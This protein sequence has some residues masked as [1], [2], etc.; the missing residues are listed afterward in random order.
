MKAVEV[1][2]YS[3]DVRMKKRMDCRRNVEEND[4]QRMEVDRYTRR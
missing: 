4:R 3:E 2:K 1:R